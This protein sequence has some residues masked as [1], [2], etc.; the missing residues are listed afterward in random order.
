MLNA[1]ENNQRYFLMYCE[2][3]YKCTQIYNFFILTLCVR[4]IPAQQGEKTCKVFEFSINNTVSVL[5]YFLVCQKISFILQR[6]SI[7]TVA[8]APSQRS[9]SCI[10]RHTFTSCP[11]AIF[12]KQDMAMSLGPPPLVTTGYPAN[13][14]SKF[15][16]RA[17]IHVVIA[18]GSSSVGMVLH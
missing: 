2:Q 16:S 3:I 5:G 6:I 14:F 12:M 10:T 17:C 7:G 15:L 9:F 11:S 13:P 1:E 18:A 8:T 4:K